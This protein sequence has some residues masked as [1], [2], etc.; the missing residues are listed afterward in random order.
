[1]YSAGPVFNAQAF[2]AFELAFVI[3]DKGNVQ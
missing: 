2:D 1:M 3:G